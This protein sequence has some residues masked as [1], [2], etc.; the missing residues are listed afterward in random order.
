MSKKQLTG[1]DLSRNN[2]L[3]I[4]DALL[5]YGGKKSYCKSD[6]ATEV[7]MHAGSI[8]RLITS[9]KEHFDIED[10]LVDVDT[11]KIFPLGYKIYRSWKRF[12]DWE[13]SVSQQK[14]SVHSNQHVRIAVSESVSNYLLPHV[15]RRFFKLYEENIEL[16]VRRFHPHYILER[17]TTNSKK[18]RIDFAI[19]WKGYDALYGNIIRDSFE[20]STTCIHALL[21]P[22]HPLAV[23]RRTVNTSESNLLELEDISRWPIVYPNLPQLRRLIYYP[24]FNSKN[25]TCVPG[26]PAVVNYVQ[27]TRNTVGFFPG[28][29]WVLNEV[30]RIYNIIAVPLNIEKEPMQLEFLFPPEGEDGLNDTAKKFLQI[31]KDTFSELT[32]IGNWSTTDDQRI[33]IGKS[34]KRKSYHLYYITKGDLNSTPVPRWQCGKLQLDSWKGNKI[35]GKLDLPFLK[36]GK[37][38]VSGQLQDQQ[39]FFLNVIGTGS[40]RRSGHLFMTRELQYNSLTDCSGNFIVL[41]GIFSY[42][43]NDLLPS[44]SPAIIS[45]QSLSRKQVF[46]LEQSNLISLLHFGDKD[47]LAK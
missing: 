44:A 45:P 1:F 18:K 3:K 34:T 20:T 40:N 39:F 36:N 13:E 32:E 16:E 26:L 43:G 31:F 28:W 23:K 47:G 41:A 12:K 9:V 5:K 21:H 37:A 17:M 22:N 33:S 27:T 24:N 2:Y 46:Q 38:N 42:Q 35:T 19:A 6:I 7:D 15:A 10:D 30:E 25:H 4:C 8:R 14:T 29:S 11:G